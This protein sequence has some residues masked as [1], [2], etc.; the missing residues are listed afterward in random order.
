MLWAN[1]EWKNFHKIKKNI[2]FQLSGDYCNVM[3]AV[4]SIVLCEGDC[5]KSL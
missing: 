3:Y 2:T 5:S 4:I 1:I